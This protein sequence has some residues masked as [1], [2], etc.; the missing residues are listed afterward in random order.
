MANGDHWSRSIE[1][2]IGYTSAAAVR[3]KAHRNVYW[4]WLLSGLDVVGCWAQLLIL[5]GEGRG[6]GEEKGVMWSDIT[7]WP[8][9][10]RSRPDCSPTV[11][12]RLNLCVSYPTPTQTTLPY[13]IPIG[14]RCSG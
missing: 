1:K 6:G 5:S 11:R 10:A 7:S 13:P 8:V 12:V 3:S 4:S 14:L 2:E 9:S